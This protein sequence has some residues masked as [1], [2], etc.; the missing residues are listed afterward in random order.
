MSRTQILTRPA[1][2]LAMA[3]SSLAAVGVVAT[4]A[5]AQKMDEKK[6][7][8]AKAPQPTKAFI[9]V[10]T[11]LKTLLDAGAITPVA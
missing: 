4:P 6:G 9:P 11:E 10:Y 1:F 3:L 7:A 2:A 8:P 5:E